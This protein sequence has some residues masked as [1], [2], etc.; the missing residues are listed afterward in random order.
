MPLRR[1]GTGLLAVII[2]L[3]ASSAMAAS[4][5]WEP[6]ETKQ[7]KLISDYREQSC[8]KKPPRA[9]T[10]H[11]QLDSKYDQSD[12][13]K[14]TLTDL[15]KET[16]AIRSHITDYHR[17][18]A[19]FVRYYESAD[20]QGE[21]NRSLA[22]LHQW[23]EAWASEGALLSTDM[24]GTGRAVRKWSLAALSSV[25]LKIHA[26]TNGEFELSAAQ[27]NWLEKLAEGVIRDYSPRQ[28]LEYQ[29]FNNHDYWAAWAVSATGMLLGR[30][31]YID[32]SEK[33]LHLALEQSRESEAKGHR[34]LPLEVAR[35]NLA[36]DYMHYAMV[37]L[38]LLVESMAAND[39]DLDAEQQRKLG[40]LANFAAR[41]VMEPGSLPELR[42]GQKEV[43]SHKMVWLLPFLKQQPFHSQARTLYRKVKDDVGFY[44]QVGGSLRSLY[45][46]VE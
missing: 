41:G 21:A 15:P 32:W 4:S 31:R 19:G 39:R 43:P 2:T 25:L 36:V 27:R 5:M 46:G 22:C 14:S 33:T 23:L 7:S 30:D 16:K 17:G 13:T 8:P 3:S 26:V 9:Y 28:T 34:Y 29:Y 20:S 11:L 45:P 6:R 10:G 38:V 40:E 18:L 12:R 35:G 37:P 1:T 24:S 42:K 44:G